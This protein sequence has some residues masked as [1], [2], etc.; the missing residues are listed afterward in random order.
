[1]TVQLSIEELPAIVGGQ[2]LFPPAGVDVIA[3]I[4]DDSRSVIPGSLFIAIKGEFT[5]GH[6]YL[7]QAVMR[8]A[9]AVIVQHVPDADAMHC[10]R[11]AGCG[12]LQWCCSR[13]DAHISLVLVFPQLPVMATTRTPGN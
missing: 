11:E 10:M 4:F 6:H 8:G 3:G 9:R 5:D 12:C 2:W 13:I 7:P 1:M